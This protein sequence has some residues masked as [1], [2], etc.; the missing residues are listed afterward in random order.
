MFSA[1]FSRVQHAPAMLFIIFRPKTIG[2]RHFQHFSAF[3]LDRGKPVWEP[4]PVWALS[5]L[6]A[7]LRAT[8][9][10]HSLTC[11]IWSY[12]HIGFHHFSIGFSI[13]QQLF[14]AVS[15]HKPLVFTTFSTFHRFGSIWGS[16]WSQG[17]AGQLLQHGLPQIKPKR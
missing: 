13:P 17:P 1:L 11:T 10:S 9:V 3:W 4:L 12:Y 15:D 5:P 16:P 8:T 6:A 2:F 14:S 7:P